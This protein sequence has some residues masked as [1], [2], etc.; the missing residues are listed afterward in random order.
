MRGRAEPT[1][2]KIRHAESREW[3]H[4]KSL[5]G[6]TR[7]PHIKR[8]FF[9]EEAKADLIAGLA[10]KKAKREAFLFEVSPEQSAN[11]K[12]R[13]LAEKG[14]GKAKTAAAATPAAKKSAKEK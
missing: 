3:W 13:R 12:A 5:E 11:R 8:F 4:L 10:L 6:W 2:R 1:Q 9:P 14:R 7:E